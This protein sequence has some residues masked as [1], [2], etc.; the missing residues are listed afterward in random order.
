MGHKSEAKKNPGIA[1]E[2]SL[3]Y[4]AARLIVAKAPIRISHLIGNF[5]YR[6]LG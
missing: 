3:A 1:R 4:R 6:H 5:C 2:N